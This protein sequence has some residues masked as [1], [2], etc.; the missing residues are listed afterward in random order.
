M[1]RDQQ[2]FQSCHPR[3]MIRQNWR[4]GLKLMTVV[5]VLANNYGRCNEKKHI[6]SDPARTMIE[7]YRITFNVNTHLIIRT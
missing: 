4:Y 3:Q 5:W 6:I 7:A 1:Y 2:F